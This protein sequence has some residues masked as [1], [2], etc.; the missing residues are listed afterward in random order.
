ME[1]DERERMH[2]AGRG[3]QVG[4]EFARGGVSA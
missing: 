3:A 2:L 1:T 4:L